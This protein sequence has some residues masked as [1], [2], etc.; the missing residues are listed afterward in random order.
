MRFCLQ[1]LTLIPLLYLPGYV[2]IYMFNFFQFCIFLTTPLFF[3][4]WLFYLS[5][6]YSVFICQLIFIYST[7][8]FIYL[9]ILKIIYIKFC[10]LCIESSLCL[11]LVNVLYLY[12]SNFYLWAEPWFMHIL[13]YL[14]VFDLLLISVSVCA[15]IVDCISWAHDVVPS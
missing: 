13:F 1:F 4:N 14:F 9:A 10:L 6:S 2:S 11:V 7:I 3:F 8:I 15:L 12:T 5:S